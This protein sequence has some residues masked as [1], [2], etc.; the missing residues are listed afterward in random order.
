M[1]TD[2]GKDD[3]ASRETK[4]ERSSR[5][6]TRAAVAGAVL[7]ALSL[8][9]AYLQWV[10]PRDFTPELEKGYA[11]LLRASYQDDLILDPTETRQ[12]NDFISKNRLR[13]ES[14]EATRR[15]LMTKIEAAFQSI[16]RGLALARQKRF[17]EAR[18]EFAS[19]AKSD[20]EN[21]AAW[22]DLGAADME[23]GRTEEGRAAYDKALF[24]APDDWRTRFNFG[25]FFARMKNPDAALAQFERVFRPAE[26]GAGPTGEQLQQVV[27]AAE[28]DPVLAGL[29][30]DPRF[31]DLLR[32]AKHGS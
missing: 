20:P 16:D 9:L 13:G 21:S 15:E 18:Q 7:A 22:A 26:S 25:L 24:L 30:K 19:A 4:N 12:L 10:A 6:Q 5:I 1:P 14:V 31:Q 17:A 27:R 29:R 28:T 23:T 11:S 2:G 8:G 3:S 32:A